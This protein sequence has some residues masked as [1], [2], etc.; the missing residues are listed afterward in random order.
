ME[1]K[2]KDAFSY[3][4]TQE[5]AMKRLYHN[6]VR[7]ESPSAD[8]EA[9]EKI[10]EHLDT[11]CDALG[12]GREIYHFEKAG[13]TFT[14]WTSPGKLAPIALIG[15]IDTV[16]P[17]GSFGE[18]PF[19]VKDNLVY[20]PGCYDMKGG[21][22][23]MLYA[24][25][26]LQKI[27]YQD[28][29]IKLL[30][31]ADEEVAHAFSDGESGH[32]MEQHLE[33]CAAAFNCESGV[34]NEEVTI[35]RKGG[36]VFVI[37]VY[38]KAA[39]AGK[40]PEKGASAILQAARMI[41]EIES[42]TVLGDMTFNCGTITGGSGANIIP[43]F[44]KFTVGVRYCTNEQY[45]EACRMIWNLCSNVSVPGTHCT[46]EQNGFYPAMELTPKTDRLLSVYQQASRMLD[47]PV[48]Q[49]IF[50]GGCSDSSYATRIGVP[51]L[52]S[53]GIQGSNAHQTSECADL[54]SLTLQC[55][56]LV[57]SILMLPD[58]F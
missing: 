41:A 43:D 20:G 25:R 16:H 4:D 1:N 15:H 31:S 2:I 51:T 34:P 27:G 8:R 9:L 53:L 38:G 58:D 50:Q 7:M 46:M 39:H 44:C 48:P 49:G 22:V 26:A 19:L 3:I 40:E 18:N 52:C 29:Q 24:L 28:R 14:A 23:I 56:K 6:L 35:R 36:A 57:A 33:G 55:K 30:L 32:I 47:R 37:K 54:S 10:A 12:M 13:P 21:D 17:V 5:E 45:E 42:H 11:Y